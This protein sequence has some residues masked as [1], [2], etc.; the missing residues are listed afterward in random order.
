MLQGASRHKVQDGCPSERN[1]TGFQTHPVIGAFGRWI[2][3]PQGF[4]DAQ[5]VAD[6]LQDT[7]PSNC[8]ISSSLQSH[9]RQIPKNPLKATYPLAF[10]SSST[11]MMFVLSW[12]ALSPP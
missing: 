6:V 10:S 9:S 2:H 3:D 1:F 12:A 4:V 11:L 7:P 5:Y 8:I